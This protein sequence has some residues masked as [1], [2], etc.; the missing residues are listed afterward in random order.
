MST[1]TSPPS[2]TRPSHT[3]SLYI[4]DKLYVSSNLF[5]KDDSE[6]AVKLPRS[7]ENLISSLASQFPEPWT[8]RHSMH[9]EIGVL[10]NWVY[11]LEDGAGGNIIEIPTG[12]DGMLSTHMSDEAG[13]SSQKVAPCANCGV[14]LACI[15]IRG[16]E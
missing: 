8:N 5:K 9:S 3:S 13:E 10:S 6:P 14:L 15:G 7:L 11:N 1:S 4:P 12:V 2:L 16:I